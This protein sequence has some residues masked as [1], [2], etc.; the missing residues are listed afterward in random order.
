MKRI[1]LLA[2]LVGSLSSASAAVYQFS[3]LLTGAAEAPANASPGLGFAV[4]SYD[5][6][7]QTL[8]LQT[9]FVG[10]MGNTTI[11][12][13]H[14]PTLIAGTGTASPATQVPTFVGFPVGVTSGLYSTTLNLTSAASYNPAFIA[15][16]G[17]TT[18]GAEAAL[19]A[20]LFGGQAYFNIHTSQF[21][22]GEIRGFFTL[23]PE[24][25]SFALLGMGAVA[26][27]LKARKK[28]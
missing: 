12:H 16:N 23:V 11:A 10:L 28:K 14:A 3:A 7:A 24:P 17:G 19:A 6:T 13:I 2:L 21:G 8:Q 4:A 22:G 27:A 18:A 1:F 15:A 26:M 9:L 25:S 5:N 20:A